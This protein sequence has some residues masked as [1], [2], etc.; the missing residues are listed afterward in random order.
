MKILLL[1]GHLAEPLIREIANAAAPHHQCNVRVLPVAVAAFL[2]PRYVVNQLKGQVRAGEFDLILLP[3]LVSGDAK[4]VQQAVG[5][6]SYKGTRHAAD[7]PVLLQALADSEIRLSTTQ[8]ADT[9]LAEERLASA[10]SELEAAEVLRASDSLP[11]GCLRI[12]SGPQSVL[13]GPGYPMRV[14][15]EITDAS[16]KS[17]EELRRLAQY[18]Q[19]SGALIIDI[20]MIAGAPDSHAASHAVKLVSRAVSVP[21][22]IDSTNADELVAGLEAG[23]VMALSLDQ[24][25]MSRIPRRLRTK[26]AFAV[27]PAAQKGE[28]LPKILEDRLALLENNLEAARR[29]GYGTLVAD[30]LCDPLVTPGLVESI[31]AYA[32][33]TRRQPTV[34]TLMGVGNVSELLDADTPGVNA[35]LAG[36]ASEVG[37][38]FLLTTEVSA[39]TRG[40]VWEL[41][42]ASQMMYLAHHRHTHPKDLGLDLLL[43]KSKQFT[44]VSYDASRESPA[45]IIDTELPPGSPPL[46]VC[47]DP[48]GYFTIHVDRHQHRIV[49]RHFVSRGKA[50]D[51]ADTTA[52][53]E[54]DLVFLGRTAV[55]VSTAIMERKLVSRMEHAAY[56][57]RELAKAEVALQTGRPYTQGS[58]LFVPWGPSASTAQVHKR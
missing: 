36:I 43:L 52:E 10:I 54:P 49:A 56:L 40:S 27:I 5:I 8:A 15:A 6:P 25:N 7:L 41:Y 20:G 37:V 4:L 38:C 58:A 24:D 19:A 22:S 28:T 3:G 31:K 1:T 57:G 53:S 39:K 42:R 18:F 34:P 2:H 32:A 26:A 48:L 35:L 14:I 55:E 13:V 30:P 29:L 47:L 33:F 11:P 50:R 23:A 17:D 21:V 12:G 9:I 44:E 16:S 45:S 46:P 51:Q